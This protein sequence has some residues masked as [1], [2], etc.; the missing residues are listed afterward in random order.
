MQIHST[1]LAINIRTALNCH[2]LLDFNRS[3]IFFF[4][5][6]SHLRKS[7]KWV[8]AGSCT[9]ICLEMRAEWRKHLLFA[10]MLGKS[11]LVYRMWCTGALRFLYCKI[12]ELS[13]SRVSPDQFGSQSNWEF[14]DSKGKH[15]EIWEN[16]IH[17]RAEMNC[18]WGLKQ[19]HFTSLHSSHSMSRYQS[20][21]RR[22]WMPNMVILH[23]RC[24]LIYFLLTSGQ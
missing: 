23:I 13:S 20:A 24:I 16:T 5:Q 15:S 1:I 21:C 19:H 14:K 22:W 11:F 4:F 18:I 17:S 7:I 2:N 12:D 9:F 6:N 10:N 3:G 8:Q